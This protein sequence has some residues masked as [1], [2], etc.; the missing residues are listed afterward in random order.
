MKR[1]GQDDRGECRPG[2]RDKRQPFRVILGLVLA[3]AFAL[4][5]CGGS[6]GSSGSGQPEASPTCD[7][8]WSG[9]IVGV[10]YPDITPRAFVLLHQGHSRFDGACGD[11]VRNLIPVAERLAENGFIVYGLEM[12]PLP[13]GPGGDFLGPSLDLIDS[14]TGQGLPIFMIGFSGGGW[15]TTMII[16][17]RPEIRRGYSVA[18]DHP[19]LSYEKG[20]WEQQNPPLDYTVAYQIAGDRLL[21]IYNWNDPCCFDHITGDIGTE[22][23]TDYENTEHNISEWALDYILEDISS[24][25]SEMGV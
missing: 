16:A 8:S 1:L 13:H 10:W 9:G 15:T 25:L 18:G 4:I 6:N 22:Y 11:E 12:P 17:M 20:D 21:H 23:L 2:T 3:L 7:G 5:G 19:V 24:L 14:L